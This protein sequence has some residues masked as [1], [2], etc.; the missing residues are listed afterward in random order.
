MDFIITTDAGRHDT[1]DWS[2]TSIGQAAK[3][4]VRQFN[5][6]D[7]DLYEG[8]TVTAEITP[9]DATR[10]SRKFKFNDQGMFEWL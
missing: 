4:F 6:R 9:V 2:G 3:S 5:F 1:N 7:Y 10:P 8:E